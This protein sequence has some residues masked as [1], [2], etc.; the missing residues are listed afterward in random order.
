LNANQDQKTYGELKGGLDVKY[1][2][3]D[4]FT[5]DAILVPDFGQTKF[6]NV[7]LNLSP[8]EQRFTENRPFFTEGTDLF[9]KGDLVYSRRIGETPD[10]VLGDTE[11]AKLPG[12]IKLINA[13]KISGRS[14]DGLGIGFLNAV[15]ENTKVSITDEA[16]G[17]ERNVELQPATNYN[18]VVLDQRFN[19]NSSVSFINT[20]VTRNGEAKDANVSALLFDL[21]TP[22][23]TFTAKGDVKYSYLNYS[24]IGQDKNGVNT[25]IYL[26]E[27]SGNFR[28]GVG[29]KYISKD[30]D[31]NDL[32]INF[33]THFHGFITEGSY[34][35]INPTK[36]YNTFNP[37]SV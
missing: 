18:V 6:D 12:S 25:S 22:R 23:N 35:I 2:I 20:N 34:R 8:F 9:S 28:Y 24:G 10:L 3:S 15:T 26:A 14:K 31:N 33:Q 29:G 30:F 4:A 32:G 13:V 1:G 36:K 7:E 17:S 27:T 11:S 16:T 19:T 37:V 5:L 21:N